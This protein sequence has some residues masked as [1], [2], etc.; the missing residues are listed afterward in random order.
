MKNGKEWTESRIA[1]IS[2]K[3]TPS[4]KPA[5]IIWLELKDDS[6]ED[7]IRI[8]RRMRPDE[9]F[10]DTNGMLW[11]PTE[12]T[13]DTSVSARYAVLLLGNESVYCT[14]PQTGEMLTFT[15]WE[16]A[17][18]C[19]ADESRKSLRLIADLSDA[20]N[21]RGYYTRRLKEIGSNLTGYY[22]KH[23]V[24]EKNERLNERIDFYLNRNSAE[25]G[26]LPYAIRSAM[27]KALFCFIR[28][29]KELTLPE[30]LF[31]AVVETPELL[32]Q[33]GTD[34][35]IDQV[36]VRLV[37][38][39]TIYSEKPIH[40]QKEVV[41]LP[42]REIASYDR[43]VV[44]LIHLDTASHPLSVTV[45]SM[46]TINN[47]LVCPREVFKTAILSNAAYIIMLHNHPSGSVAPSSDDE[48]ITQRMATLCSMMSIPLT[49]HIIVAPNQYKFLG[50]DYYSFKEHEKLPEGDAEFKV[51][52]GKISWTDL[53]ESEVKKMAK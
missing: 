51:T 31:S 2:A 40:S 46:G 32:K 47:S 7:M 44:A 37:R 53:T 41:E 48:N 52:D 5:N 33:P 30:N 28:S 45:C 42:G 24:P 23:P 1:V 27:R 36:G 35:E 39:R 12:W 6:L 11:R 19:A 29:G 10:F 16:D 20:E 13:D 43:E 17:A 8:A 14:D 18:N 38:E 25:A 9:V 3:K 50:F 49:D 4:N 26:E 22:D 15:T 21:S 34:R